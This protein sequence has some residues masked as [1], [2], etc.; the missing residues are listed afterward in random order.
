MTAN[1]QTDSLQEKNDTN[2]VRTASYDMAS[3]DKE[4]NF[5]ANYDDINSNKFNVDQQEIEI[6]EP[7]Q[8]KC[9]ER[10]RNLIRKML[11]SI[12][13]ESMYFS[14]YYDAM[15]KDDYVQQE[16]MH[17]PLAYLSQSDLNTMHFHQA[18][19]EPDK[20]EFVKAIVLE[21]NTHTE[22]KHWKLVPR[23]KVPEG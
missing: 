16:L 21:V 17:Q 9:S 4:M 19:K 1:N 22:P 20:E 5:D 8:T 3:P 12:A 15:H 6:A 23:N 11:E 14:T 10:K 18:M 7:A 2:E 13:Q